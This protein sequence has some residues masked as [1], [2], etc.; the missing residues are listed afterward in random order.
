VT[1]LLQQARTLAD[2]ASFISIDEAAVLTAADERGQ[3]A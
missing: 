3:S 2:L 1:A